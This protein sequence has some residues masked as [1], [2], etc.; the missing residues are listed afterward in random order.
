MNQIFV[1]SWSE[2]DKYND[3]YRRYDFVSAASEKEARLYAVEMNPGEAT[4][5]CEHCGKSSPIGLVIYD[6]TDGNFWDTFNDDEEVWME[7]L[8]E[9]AA[10]DCEMAAVLW[11][12][13]TA[14]N[15][16]EVLAIDA[17]RAIV[18]QH[19]IDLATRGKVAASGAKKS[20]SL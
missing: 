6:A 15:C 2:Y 4:H 18:E 7:A 14:N 1:F 11:G 16:A 19:E 8:L 20:K 17:L 3:E 9:W 10:D 13:A 12:M 5:H